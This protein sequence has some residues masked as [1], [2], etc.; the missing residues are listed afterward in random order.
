MSLYIISA[1][2]EFLQ[3]PA[4]SYYILDIPNAVAS[5][6]CQIVET[7]PPEDAQTP[8]DPTIF[9]NSVPIDPYDPP[10]R[11]GL[12]VQERVVVGL[13]IAPVLAQ[14]AGTVIWC[15]AESQGD[16]VRS[17][18][19]TI[20]VGGKGEGTKGGAEGWGDSVR[21]RN[22]TILVGGKGAEGRGEEGGAEER[23]EE[24][25]AEE[26]GERGQRRGGRRVGQRRG[27]R[28]GRGEGGGGWG[29]GEGGEGWGRG[30][31]GQ[32]RGGAEGQVS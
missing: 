11:H 22:A 2:L 3:Q 30:E 10:S 31:R 19:A 5:I 8:V 7:L 6:P 18:N 12:L 14:D 13:L 23:G 29:R 9:I 27:G 15:E 25:G 26:R 17:R 20:L 28:G 32:R 4:P 21:S 16:S 24:G 1:V